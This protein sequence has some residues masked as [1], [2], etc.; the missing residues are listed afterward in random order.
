[1]RIGVLNNLRAGRSKAQISRVLSLLKRHP[2]VVHVETDSGND[3]ATALAALADHQVDVLAVNGGDGTLQRTL[4]DVLS[5]DLFKSPPLIVPLRGGRTNM[6]ALDIGNRSSP[7]TALAALVTAARNGSL[8]KKIVERAVLRV[9]IIPDR[10]VQYGMSFGVGVIPRAIE[11]THSLFPYG[12]AQG[13]FGSGVVIG[14]LI[15][16]A[17][18]NTTDGILTPDRI[19]I[20]LDDQ[21][22]EQE[23]FHLVIATTLDRLFLK[24]RPFWGQETAPVRLTAIAAGVSRSPIAAIR[25]LRGRSP[26]AVP[27]PSYMSRNVHHAELSLDCGLTVDGEMFAPQP[28][29]IVHITADHRTRFVRI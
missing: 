1:M 14:T 22:V 17:A 19:A 11:L 18:F 2:D 15:T 9:D 29:R 28:G 4:T 8:E 6:S 5:T 13:V 23:E 12:R 26:T 24:I 16:R 21:P 27:D 3:V 25:I 10:I 7:V 20:R